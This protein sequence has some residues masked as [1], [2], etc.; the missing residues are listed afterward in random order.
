[1]CNLSTN[2]SWISTT[3]KTIATTFSIPEWKWDQI[4]MD[5]VIGLPRPTSKQYA[6]WVVVDRLFKSALFVPYKTT[7]FIQKMTKLYIR[8]IDRLHGVPISIV[9]DRVPRFTSK[10][11]KILHEAI[12]TKLNFSKAYHP[13]TD[14]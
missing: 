6:I 12:E 8:E 4:A 9:S 10:F 14:G 2:K 5:F 3:G 11:W 7:D 1:M 13:Q